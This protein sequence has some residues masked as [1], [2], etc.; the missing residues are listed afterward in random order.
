MDLYFISTLSI[1]ILESTSTNIY[2]KKKKNHVKFSNLK[3]HYGGNKLVKTSS[4]SFFLE[5]R[6]FGVYCRL[7][8]CHCHTT[9]TFMCEE[10][11]AKQRSRK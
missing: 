8:Y 1:V 7:A 9:P 10:R 4:S 6:G 11:P 3:L 5:T 2:V